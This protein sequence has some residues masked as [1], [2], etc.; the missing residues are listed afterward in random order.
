MG[1]IQGNLHRVYN[2]STVWQQIIL[3]WLFWPILGLVIALSITVYL[4][5]G[6]EKFRQSEP[7]DYPIPYEAWCVP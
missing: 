4:L 1:I 7:V 6:W 2:S 5:G 3:Y